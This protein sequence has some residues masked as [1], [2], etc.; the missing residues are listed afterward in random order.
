MHLPR[1]WAVATQPRDLTLVPVAC[2]SLARE[3]S[4]LRS[5]QWL[6]G[7]PVGDLDR[8]SQ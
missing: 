3:L 2:A 4:Q 7:S 8:G 6:I 1:A 5:A